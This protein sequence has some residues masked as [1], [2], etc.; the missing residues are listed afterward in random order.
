MCRHCE[1]HRDEAIYD[2]LI[3]LLRGCFAL[4]AP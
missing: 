1:E 3:L 2:C 4:L